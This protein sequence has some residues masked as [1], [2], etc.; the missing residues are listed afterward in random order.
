MNDDMAMAVTDTDRALLRET[1]CG[2]L[3]SGQFEDAAS[4]AI[5]RAASE[6]DLSAADASVVARV[7]REEWLAM[8]FSPLA[9]PL[10]RL[11][12]RRR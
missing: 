5:Q 3:A 9:F 6:G 7:G 1:A 10:A 12:A 2:L 8:G 4:Q 11:L